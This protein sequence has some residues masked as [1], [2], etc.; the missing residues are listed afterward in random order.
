M[1]PEYAT[2]GE[3]TRNIS[4]E[5]LVALGL[6]RTGPQQKMLRPLV[7]PPAHRFASLAAEVERRVAQQGLTAGVQWALPRFVDGSKAVGAERIPSSGPL[8]VASNHP[9]SYDG[10]VIASYLSRD[11]LKVLVSDVPFLRSLRASSSHFLYTPGDA[12]KRMSAIRESV[13]HLRAGGALLVFASAQVDP[14]PAF[15]PGAH[16]ALQKWSPSLPL[17]LRLVPEAKMLVTIVSGVLAPSCYRHPLTRLRKEQRLK[18]FL[19]EFIQVGQQVLFKRRFGL[20]P[21]VQFGE[22]L[23]AAV[24]EDTR[25]TRGALDAITMQ[26]AELISD[27]PAAESHSVKHSSR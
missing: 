10:L 24:L 6:P 15:L 4:T 17:F 23:T 9:G 18:Q 14:D 20:C 13:R 12:H 22:P 26:A 7:W 25:G 19:A 8:V 5:I 21:M 11:D 16:D 1:T 2:V 3:L 27:I